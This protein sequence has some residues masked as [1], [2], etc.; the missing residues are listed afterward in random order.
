LWSACAQFH[1]TS[2]T[3]ASRRYTGAPLPHTMDS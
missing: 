3:L 1:T 2:L